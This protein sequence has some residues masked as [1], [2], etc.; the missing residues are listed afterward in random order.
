MNQVS[1]NSTDREKAL[2]AV[3]K[4]WRKEGLKRWEFRDYFGKIGDFKSASLKLFIEYAKWEPVRTANSIKSPISVTEE[5]LDKILELRENIKSGY[6][7]YLYVL[8]DYD[9]SIK[10]CQPLV[11][12]EDAESTTKAILE[13]NKYKKVEIYKL[14]A[15]ESWET[16]KEDELITF[17]QEAM[18]LLNPEND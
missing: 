4:L 2:H 9:G 3:L 10:I 1:E 12:H 15:S 16:I 17:N 6:C 13:V 11:F 5:E 8:H 14:W 7:I 18:N